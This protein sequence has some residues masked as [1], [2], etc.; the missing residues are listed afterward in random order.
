[1][2]SSRVLLMRPSSALS[3]R[4]TTAFLI[5]HGGG[6][7]RFL[8]RSFLPPPPPPQ[9]RN[10]RQHQLRTS[11]FSRR[12]V[13]DSGGE[14]LKAKSVPVERASTS[15]WK[16]TAY[17][18]KVARLPFLI[19][20]IYGLGYRQGVTDTVRNPL[21]LQQGTFETL[22]MEMD[23]HS[24]DDVEVISERG[25]SGGSTLEWFLGSSKARFHHSDNPRAVRVAKVGREIIQSARRY[26][27][28][29]LD[30]AVEKAKESYKGVYLKD[31]V[32]ARKLNEDPQV[33]F[34]VHALERIEGASF[35]G[36]EN[37]Q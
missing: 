6:A 30:E 13:T 29:K 12:A 8:R 2:L 10:A 19:V 35:E 25:R 18:F 15:T 33:E 24:D 1:M 27:R 34:W 28:S 37:W 26:V 3:R 36:V 5:P 31:H 7:G 17:Y 16:R 20:A 4:A 21:K 9:H 11:I 32:L 14:G 23:V 22:L